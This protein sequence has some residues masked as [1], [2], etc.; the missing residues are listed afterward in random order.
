MSN[1]IE[2]ISN[3]ADMSRTSRA[4]KAQALIDYL[5]R[6]DTSNANA[7]H[8]DT[9]NSLEDSQSSESNTS[10]SQE[11]NAMSELS[12]LDQAEIYAAMQQQ[13]LGSKPQKE[14]HSAQGNSAKNDSLSDVGKTE[15]GDKKSNSS[16]LEKVIGFLEQLIAQLKSQQKN[17]NSASGSPSAGAASG[18]NSCKAPD[19]A[20][21][22]NQ[23]DS[24]A[25]EDLEKLLQFFKQ[26]QGD[27]K[28]QKAASS[29]TPNSD[30]GNGSGATPAR[31]AANTDA[32]ATNMNAD[33]L[34]NILN[35]LDKMHNFIKAE[36]SSEVA[37]NN[38]KNTDEATDENSTNIENAS[39]ANSSSNK[40]ANQFDSADLEQLLELLREICGEQKT[41]QP[42]QQQQ[43]N[44]PPSNSEG[45]NDGSGKTPPVG[46]T[47]STNGLNTNKVGTQK[48]ESHL[49]TKDSQNLPPAYDKPDP[50][51]RSTGKI[52]PLSPTG[53]LS[54]DP[55]VKSI[56][57]KHGMYGGGA[58][59]MEQL[60]DPRYQKAIRDQ[61]N[62]ITAENNMKWGELEKSGYGP[63][64]EVVDW[65]Q[66]NDIKV[67]GHALVW[68]EQA[69]DR[70]KNMGG[71]ELKQEV[72]K[73]I[74]DTMKHFGNKVPTW[75][76]VN[77]TFS[78]KAAE[79]KANG[80]GGFRDSS[81]D[82]KGSPFNE[83][84]GGQQFL[85]HA[86]KTARAANPKAELVLNDYNVE[87]KN[88]KSDAM[89]EAVKS[90]KE[91]GIPIDA[92]GFQAHVKA[93][94]DLSTMEANIK[95]F[96]DLGV[97]VQITELD[98]AG[99]SREEKIKTEKAVFDAA[100]KGGASGITFWGVSDEHSWIG[101][102]PGLVL[103]KDMKVK[104]DLLK[105]LSS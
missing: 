8:M 38:I 52:S 74:N 84:I 77:E 23:A 32:A 56:A 72:G 69:P 85:D 65:A 34:E 28:S 89:Y 71:N 27:S 105:A 5:N 25:I 95:R 39:D 43:Y 24:S 13:M 64:D 47:G 42:Q 96:K 2:R 37:S 49:S 51:S 82:A 20:G 98:V 78:D 53:T 58:V 48:P 86:F 26:L 57:A 46:G 31:D 93:G 67:R 18:A 21:L 9:P 14:T 100:A 35:F 1:T 29:A 70:I 17:Q 60:K 101:N 55:S 104:E 79:S 10:P 92:V 97:N 50:T 91:R 61:F 12:L 36:N 16:D 80:K 4:S 19:A 59:D 15:G 76:V 75:D 90:M 6:P 11:D 103:D 99:G 102:D 68:H 83:K 22:K 88:D 41:Q 81:T 30:A 73:H 62:V 54:N 45:G 44:Q 87:T 94:Q 63:A 33:D 7:P 66:K 3:D 40:K